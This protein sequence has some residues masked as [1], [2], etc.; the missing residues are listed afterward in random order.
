MRRAIVLSIIIG[1]GMVYIALGWLIL[2]LA[3]Q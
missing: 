2:T 3:K 1:L